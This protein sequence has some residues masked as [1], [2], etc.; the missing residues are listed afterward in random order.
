MM[1]SSSE[2]QERQHTKQRTSPHKTLGSILKYFVDMPLRVELK[3]G[4][5][6]SGTLSGADM[7]MS[8]TLRDVVQTAP[9]P[10]RAAPQDLTTPN[11]NPTNITGELPILP[12]MQIRGS[13]IRYIHFPDKVDLAGVIKAGIQR[14]KEAVDKYKRGVRKGPS[15]ALP[16]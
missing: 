4:S 15:K 3:N 13:T 7:H 12:W 6:Y 1:A 8:L 14:E 5:I 16:S 9:L 11:K 2:Q 10:A